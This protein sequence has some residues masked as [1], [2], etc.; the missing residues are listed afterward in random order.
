[1]SSWQQDALDLDRQARSRATATSNID[2]HQACSRAVEALVSEGGSVPI[3]LRIYARTVRL[4]YGV[5][6]GQ[7]ASSS[8][9]AYVE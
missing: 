9:A 6:A 5:P 2:L 7:V 4:M 8:S 3:D 1:M